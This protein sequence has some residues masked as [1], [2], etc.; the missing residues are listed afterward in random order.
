MKILVIEDD[1]DFSD[2][3]MKSLAS[4][5]HSP[6]AAFNWFSVMRT[7]EAD[8]FDLIVTD[9]ETPTGNALNAFDFL[10]REEK[11]RSIPKIVITGREGQET[12]RACLAIGAV[13][14]HKSTTSIADLK[15][16]LESLSLT[17]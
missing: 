9:I 17:S 10:N 14:I 16:E 7:L 13:Y 12:Q 6:V 4:W 15:A 5:G 8:D 2:I 11:V 3:L 1:A